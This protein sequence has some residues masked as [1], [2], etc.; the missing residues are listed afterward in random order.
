MSHQNLKGWLEEYAENR[1]P[2]EIAQDLEQH[3]AICRDCQDQLK[4]IRLTRGIVRASRLEQPPVPASG[5]GRAVWQTIEQQR[6]LYSFWNPLRRIAFRS[7]PAMAAL[8][9]VIGMFAYFEISSTLNARQL[10]DEPLLETS[11]ELS[12]Q[13]GQEAAV[14]SEGISQDQEEAVSTLLEGQVDSSNRGKEPRP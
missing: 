1:L 12:S 9:I 14:F 10:P 2:S 8:A 4:T 13:W 6:E 11:L 7:I 5:F 3:L